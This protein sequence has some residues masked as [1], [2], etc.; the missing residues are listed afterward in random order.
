MVFRG[1]L[2][3]LACA[4]PAAVALAADGAP[5]A[6][7]SAESMPSIPYPPLVEARLALTSDFRTIPPG[8]R[9]DLSRK[10]KVEQ[11][12]S[13]GLLAGLGAAG[14]ATAASHS[15][16]GA[17]MYVMIAG[18]NQAEEN[19]R[20]DLGRLIQSIDFPALVGNSLVALLRERQ[21]GEP[22][23]ATLQVLIRRY[24]LIQ[25]SRG[26]GDPLCL[27]VE[28]DIVLL[29]QGS[30]RHR[31]QVAIWPNSMQEGAPPASCASRSALA[32]NDGK[33][34]RRLFADYGDTLAVLAARRLPQLPWR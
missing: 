24:G 5:P 7:D 18:F 31:S 10:D 11:A 20:S 30:E 15:V 3:T 23:A 14:S 17:M 9:V 6:A 12:T 25:G 21:V 1:F 26:P 22:D 33:L 19:Q 28:A 32:D 13:L 34:M 4:I 29:V 16:V 2:V 27:M 8:G